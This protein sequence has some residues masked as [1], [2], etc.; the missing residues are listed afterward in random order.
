MCRQCA[1][2]L[3]EKAG[4]DKA[5]I[6]VRLA[7]SS[8]HKRGIRVTLKK[9]EREVQSH[10]INGGYVLFE[11]TPFGHYSLLFSKDGVKLGSYLFEIKES[12]D[13]R[14]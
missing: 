5:N 3:Y 4:K 2:T 13:G 1:V 7:E 14:G 6:R 8:K 9:G 11:D 12:Q 10:L